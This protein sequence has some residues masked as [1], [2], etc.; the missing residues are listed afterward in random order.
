MADKGWRG[1]RANADIGCLR[2]AVVLATSDI[3]DKMTNKYHEYWFFL[4]SPLHFYKF[5]LNIVFS[6]SKLDYS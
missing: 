1:G 5:W 3:T 6:F 2:G 4:N